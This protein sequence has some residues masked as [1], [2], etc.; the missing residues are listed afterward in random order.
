M[1]SRALVLI[2]HFSYLS[3]PVK[4]CEDAL[5]RCS[6]A[7]LPK[8]LTDVL[9]EMSMFREP[10]RASVTGRDGRCPHWS[11]FTSLVSSPC[12]VA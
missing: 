9:Y 3:L 4:E 6:D 2:S 12:G 1:N 10:V 8:G 7:R 11:G 5:T